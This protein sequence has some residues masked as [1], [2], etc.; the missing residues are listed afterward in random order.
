MWEDGILLP[1]LKKLVLKRVVMIDNRFGL[2]NSK[3]FPTLE[4][5]QL[6]SCDFENIHEFLGNFP[7]LK[8]IKMTFNQGQSNINTRLSIPNLDWLVILMT[9]NQG[10]SG[11]MQVSRARTLK[12]ILRGDAMEFESNCI[13]NLFHREVVKMVKELFLTDDAH[14]SMVLGQ[15]YISFF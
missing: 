7:C 3:W 15:V 8:I 6:L 13:D 11:H 14:V 2:K 12:W 4:E 10:V 5:L 9:Q 1:N